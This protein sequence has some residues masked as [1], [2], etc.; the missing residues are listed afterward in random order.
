MVSEDF[1]ITKALIEPKEYEVDPYM[2]YLKTKNI[3]GANIIPM[4]EI[5]LG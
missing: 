4:V 2:I 1:K 3:P 5:M